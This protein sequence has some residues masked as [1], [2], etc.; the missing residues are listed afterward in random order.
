MTRQTVA[1]ADQSYR[2]ICVLCMELLF[3]AVVQRGSR[4]MAHTTGPRGTWIS[5][6]TANPC[7]A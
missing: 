5:W 3:V 2:I 1:V 6:V 7:R 4:H